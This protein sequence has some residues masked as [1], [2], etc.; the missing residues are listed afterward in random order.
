MHF[1]PTSKYRDRI[2]E[3]LPLLWYVRTVS[4]MEWVALTLSMTRAPRFSRVPVDCFLGEKDKNARAQDP[5]DF[6]RHC[7]GRNVVLSRD[8]QLTSRPCVDPES[9]TGELG[10]FTFNL[11][12]TTPMSSVQPA[13]QLLPGP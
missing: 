6:G 12:L 7:G 9:R 4:R 8:I 2:Y 10:C 5:Y 1:Q 13:I 3:Y 11:T